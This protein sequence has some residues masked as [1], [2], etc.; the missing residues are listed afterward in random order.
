MLAFETKKN[1]FY[2]K[3]K[4]N[5]PLYADWDRSPKWDTIAR[6]TLGFNIQNGI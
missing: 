6:F 2:I 5:G 4:C 3:E 1:D